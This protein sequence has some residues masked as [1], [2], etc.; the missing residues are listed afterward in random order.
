MAQFTRVKQGLK[1]EDER[2]MGDPKVFRG[3]REPLELMEQRVNG[4]LL[5]MMITSLSR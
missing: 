4:A 3:L 2:V 1:R 5:R